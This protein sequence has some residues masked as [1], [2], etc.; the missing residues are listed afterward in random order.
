M[1]VTEYRNIAEQVQK[2]K[3]DI[4]EWFKRQEA[5]SVLNM[6]IMGRVDEFNELPVIGNQIGDTWAVGTEDPYTY[7]IYVDDNQYEP[8]N[9]W[10][11]FGKLFIEGPQ[12]L[13]GEKGDQGETGSS[14][15]WLIGTR[16]PVDPANEYDIYLNINDG[17]VYQFIAGVWVRQG[18]IKGA[19]GPSGRIGDQ[20]PRGERG[21]AGPRGPEGSPSRIITIA[22]KVSTVDELPDP[23]IVPPEAGYLVGAASPYNLYIRWTY[24]GVAAWHN[25]GPFNQGTAVTVDGQFVSIFDADTKLDRAGTVTVT[26]VYARN[27]NE[28]AMIKV[29]E[30]PLV[31]EASIVLRDRDIGTFYIDD[32]VYGKNPA[33][34]DYVDELVSSSLVLIPNG[35]RPGGGENSTVVKDSGNASV[36]AR[37]LVIG[38]NN[39][40]LTANNIVY[41]DG[42]E[43]A[44]GSKA[45]LVGG[46]QC[47]VT[48]S[49]GVALGRTCEAGSYD[50]AVGN[51][52]I[53][54]GGASGAI[55]IQNTVTG[56]NSVALGAVQNISGAGSV[57]CGSTNQIATKYSFTAGTGNYTYGNGTHGYCLGNSNNIQANA[58]NGALGSGNS[59]NGATAWALGRSN[60]VSGNTCFAIGSGNT[61]PVTATQSVALGNANRVEGLDSFAVGVS[62]TIHDQGPL[63][64]GFAIGSYLDVNKSG[65]VVVGKANDDTSTAL[66][67]VGNGYVAGSEVI[68]RGNAFEVMPDNTA[69]VKKVLSWND[70]A[71][72]ALPENTIATHRLINELWAE[73]GRLSARIT[74]LE[75]ELESN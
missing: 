57:A 48:G 41:G 21:P 53:A 25:V 61:L 58:G 39:S 7:Y 66:F 56:N 22:G 31:G 28:D 4:L 15:K 8:E 62:N 24:A 74:E 44:T 52:N 59:V 50:F 33:T 1:N 34:K 72:T 51:T 42:S 10:F 75:T 49:Y 40:S 38:A 5:L 73:I 6:R 17:Y 18:N 63:V 11:E 37:S 32:P 65:Q 45:C 19:T 20:G 16:E 30:S 43:A 9:H 13:K 12:G 54:K 68:T 67:A 47:K 14:T 71:Y 70:P 36:G 29:S 35:L 64:G 3:E 60:G 69:R 26:S 27:I 23:D 55:G 2:N 46:K